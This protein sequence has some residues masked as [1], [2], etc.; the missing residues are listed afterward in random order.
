LKLKIK[1]L[2]KEM[3]FL[4]DFQ[5]FRSERVGRAGKGDFARFCCTFGF[6]HVAKNIER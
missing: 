2:K 6:H 5:M 4:G 3:I 1:I